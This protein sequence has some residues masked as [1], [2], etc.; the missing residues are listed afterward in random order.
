M[1]RIP[2]TQPG[3]YHVQG[4]DQDNGREHVDEQ[5]AGGHESSAP[6]TESRD[7]IPPHSGQCHREQ[8]RDD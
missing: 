3:K 5:N 7:G 8:H 6:K 1:N 4:D 2:Q